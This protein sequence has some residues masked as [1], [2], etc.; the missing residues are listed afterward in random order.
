MAGLNGFVLDAATHGE[1]GILGDTL[2]SSGWHLETGREL[3][4]AGFFQILWLTTML[5]I[6]WTAPNSQQQ[7]DG[8][9]LA[10][11]TAPGPDGARILAWRPAL[12][13]LAVTAVLL[14]ISVPHIFVK[15]PFLYFQF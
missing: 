9:D 4:F 2:V 6:V 14:L 1:L 12:E 8:L 10:S 11:R 5:T 13:W 7:I 15:R 3:A